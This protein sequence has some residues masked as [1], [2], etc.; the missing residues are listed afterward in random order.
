MKNII[1]ASVLAVG[2]LTA[3]AQENVKTEEV[4]NPHWYVQAQAGFQNTLGEIGY[5]DLNSFNFQVGVGYQFTQ[6]WGARFS[7][8]GAQ[9]KAGFNLESNNTQYKWKWNY[10]APSLDATFNLTNAVWGFNAKRVVDFNLIAG[11]GLN[12]ASSNDDAAK[13]NAAI[14]ALNPHASSPA[15]GHVWDGTICNL[16]GRLGAAMDFRLNSNWALGLEFNANFTNDRY[17]SKHAE[18]ADW[19]F[20]TLAG[21]KYSFGKTTKTR[22]TVLEPTYVE[23]EVIKT[24]HDTVYVTVEATP[25]RE[26]MRRDIFFVIRGSEVS[27][28]EMPKIEDVVAYL[29]KYQDAKVTITGYADKKTGSD[30]INMMYSQKRADMVADILMNKFGIASNRITTTAKGSSEQP[31]ESNDLNRVSIMIAE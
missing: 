30:K 11:F 6:I 17:N 2:A 18:N 26:A 8:N 20:N 22:T 16:V 13:A 21:V 12:I 10:W 27:K 31:F 19:Y 28:A 3:S 1:L 23:K 14:G 7:V 24:V 29:N 15:L 4:F 25:A 5:S 9:S